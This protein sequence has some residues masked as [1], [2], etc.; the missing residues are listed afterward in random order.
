M[1]YNQLPFG[2]HESDVIRG[3]MSLSQAAKI[4]MVQRATWESITPRPK[5]NTIIQPD[6]VQIT[7]PGVPAPHM[8]G[9]Y[10]CER[11]ALTDTDTAKLVT[12]TIEHYRSQG[13]NFRW[14]ICET[15]RPA[16]IDLHLKDAGMILKDLLYGFYV[17]TSISYP[18]L[19]SPTPHEIK[20]RELSLETLEDWLEVQRTAWGVPPQGIEFLRRQ[21]PQELTGIAATSFVPIAYWNGHPVA[22]GSL[23]RFPGVTDYTYLAGAAVAPEYR[24]R[25]VYRAHLAERIRRSRDLG[26]PV[27]IH[28]VST[29]SAPICAALGFEKVCEIESYELPG[30][31]SLTRT[32]EFPPARNQLP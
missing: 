19:E 17:D 9:V 5:T 29:T 3:R 4:E 1:G 30:G 10:R 14:K 26:L 11:P 28:C 18:K 7:T 12:S 22:A 31:F 21:V 32:S 6:W 15:T 27:V 8:N 16:N 2:G 24:G 25:G 23:Q 20:F 13:S